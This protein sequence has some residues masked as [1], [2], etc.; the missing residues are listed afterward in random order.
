[1]V[2]TINI[3]Y[4]IITIIYFI[5]EKSLIPR[6]AN[7]VSWHEESTKQ[8]LSVSQ[9]FQQSLHSLMITLNQANPFFIRCIKSNSDKVWEIIKLIILTRIKVRVWELEMNGLWLISLVA[10]LL[11]D[12]K[13]IWRRYCS[14]AVEV[15]GNAWNSTDT[16]GGV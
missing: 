3:S 5:Q 9:Q 8:P 15:Y 14:K 16:S 1:M 2:G 12:S 11:I 7:D 6:T 4:V 10:P 13:Q